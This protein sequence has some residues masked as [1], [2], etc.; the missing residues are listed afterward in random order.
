MVYRIDDTTAVSALPAL[1]TDDIGNPG[2]FTGGST[3]GMSATRVRYWWLNMVQEEL[4]SPVSAAGLTPDKSNNT[5]LL[6]AIKVLAALAASNAPRGMAKFTTSGNFTVPAGVYFIRRR[7]WGAGGA[8]GGAKGTGAGAG[9]GG[10][11]FAEDVL[12]VTPGQVLPVTIGAG[13]VGAAGANGTSGG[14][15]SMSG[16]TCPGGSY[17]TYG[18]SAASTGFGYGG[19]PTGGTV[20]RQGGNGQGAS[21][22]GGTLLGGMGGA[23]YGSGSAP[24]VTGV[25]ANGVSGSFPGQG[26]GGGIG[27]GAIG[28]SGAPGE[29]DIY[30]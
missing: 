18:D 20:A 9:G 5:Q 25:T 17:G 22:A 27:D 8:G 12:A 29:I 16:I 13:G 14:T 1:P 28:G 7:V 21:A 3:G 6:Q 23:S 19:I 24:F 15:T 30:W 2:F 26:G 4:L 11:A 10:G